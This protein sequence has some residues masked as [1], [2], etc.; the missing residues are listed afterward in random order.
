MTVISRTPSPILHTPHP[1]LH[2]TC[3]RGLDGD[4]AVDV[5]SALSVRLLLRKADQQLERMRENGDDVS[6]APWHAENDSEADRDSDGDGGDGN[7]LAAVSREMRGRIESGDER[8]ALCGDVVASA[9]AA[10]ATGCLHVFHRACLA[11]HRRTDSHDCPTCRMPLTD[12]DVFAGA[13]V[14]ASDAV[15]HRG[16]P[17]RSDRG[18][19]P[20]KVA[21]LVEHL[22]V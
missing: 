19:Y 20:G 11:T 4:V 9:A 17:T 22:K 10:V 21:V 13:D 7:L 2:P 3:L 12:D 6:V 1:H 16:G 15:D 5:D 14:V 8:C 18:E